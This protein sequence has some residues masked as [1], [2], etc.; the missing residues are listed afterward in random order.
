MS[1]EILNV[2]CTFHVTYRLLGVNH[3]DSGRVL[4]E[5]KIRRHDIV[6][7]TKVFFGV[8]Y[9]WTTSRDYLNAQMFCIQERS[10]CYRPV[11]QAVSSKQ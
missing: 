11:S 10:Q 3:F 7:S 9:V 5:L 4:K 6:I 1:K 2:K 8:R